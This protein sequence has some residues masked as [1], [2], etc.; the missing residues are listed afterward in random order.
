[1]RRPHGLHLALAVVG[2]VGCQSYQRQPLDIPGYATGWVERSLDVEPIH[3]YAASLAEDSGSSGLFDS[4]D[5][6][7]L[8]EAEAVALH[9][10]PQLRVARIEAGV[11]L[12]GAR[13]AGWWPDPKFELKVLRFVDRGDQGRL[14]FDGPSIS[15]I[16]ASG[17]ETTPL[18]F[19][20]VE[21]DFV[22]DP[23]IVGAGLS[24]TIPVSGRL[25]VEQDLMWSR[26]SAAWRRILVREWEL[27]TGLRAAWL[28]WSASV[29]R[30]GI[31]QDHVARIEAIAGVAQQLVS[32]GEMRPTEGRL[33]RIEL[34][35]RRSSILG[36]RREQ[37]QNRLTLLSLMGLAPD[38]PVVL[39]PALIVPVLD[40]SQ[41]HRRAEV[42][43]HHP[44]I[45]SLEAEYESAEQKLRME[46]RQQYPDLDLGPSYSFEEGLSRLGLGL[47]FKIPLWNRNRQAI[48]EAS[49]ARDAM[50]VRLQVVVES[51]LS[52]LA[53][54]EA[55]LHYASRQR[56]SLLE[57]VAPLVDQQVNDSRAL[58]DLGEVDV[59]LLRIALIGA[60]ETRLEV[61][62]TAL[63]EASAA[64]NLQQMLQPRWFTPSQSES[65]E[66]D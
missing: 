6:L 42:V 18:G 27:I 47:G 62:D 11:P 39:H 4:A 63:L 7:S 51:V 50:G 56:A 2:I 34:V 61:L 31:T 1:M 45:R 17:F 9:F 44:R 23:W 10:N 37:E 8:A 36:L 60:L 66:E 12:A 35:R 14:K 13:E 5:G 26:Y 46:I 54:A 49:A 48:A 32:A 15:G 52:E 59:K 3:T 28:E 29:E 40:L 65:K 20:Q 58:L 25:A 43:A 38:A 33:L 19:R 41:E 22:E 24:I 30:L 21:G 57:E 16:N 55:R 53:Q 64:S